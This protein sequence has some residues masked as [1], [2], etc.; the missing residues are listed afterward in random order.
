MDHQTIAYKIQNFF[1]SI[2]YQ[3]TQNLKKMLGLLFIHF[4]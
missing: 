1:N 3:L 4:F 2:K